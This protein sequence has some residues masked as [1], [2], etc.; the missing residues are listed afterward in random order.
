[1]VNQQALA[2]G[3]PPV[4]FVNPAIYAI[5]KGPNYTSDFHD[6]T[7]GNNFSPSSPA[8]FPAVA[9][10][11][12]CTGWGT[13]NGINLINA[14]AIPDALG[15]LPGTGFTST[16]T[17]GGPFSVTTQNFSLTNSG[18]TSFSWLLIGVPSWLNASSS[19]GTLTAGGSASVT[20][21][22]NSTA[23]SL[24]P[25]AYAASLWFSNQ[26]T[27]VAQTR[28]FTL[29]VQPSERVQNGGFETGNFSFWTL[30]G[31]DPYSFVDD[32]SAT[33]LAPHSGSFLAALGAPGPSLAYLSQTVS[34]S[35]GQAYLL[36]LWLFNSS[37]N[38]GIPNEFSVT[39]NGNLLFD[40]ANI[41]SIGWTNLKFIVTATGSN[42][43][44]Q[45]GQYNAAWYF[46]VD[47]VS[48]APLPPTVLQTLTKTNNTFLVNW[49]AL[50][51]LVYQVQYKTNLL[52]TNWINLGSPI[53]ATSYT[54]TVTNS[55]GP[56]R[57]RF[58]R[59]VVS[60]Q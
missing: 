52:S 5:G 16:G 58:Y 20:V 7:T 48:V 15:I 12:L 37:I 4:G 1:L 33:T 11:D 29:T 32:G 53:T 57:Q 28:Q 14:L 45:L 9:G 47:D 13:P 41:G 27:H 30:T 39:W 35:P 31:T 25:G 60:T 2:H 10:Y 23:N 40:E 54:L 36:S 42:T 44:L 8:N 6:V 43:A 26:T 21:S 59:T 22:L 19:G 50:T 24:T 34:T 38:G 46:G 55:I 3:R 18:G 17:A 56:D 51:G 49:A